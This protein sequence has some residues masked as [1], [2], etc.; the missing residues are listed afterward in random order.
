MNW[1]DDLD[2]HDV[3]QAKNV[4]PPEGEQILDVKDGTECRVSYT[5][6]QFYRAKIVGRGKHAR[7]DII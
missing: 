1:L 7:K 4:V 3:V 5:D 2:L 6:G